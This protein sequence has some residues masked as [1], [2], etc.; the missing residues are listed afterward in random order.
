M[1]KVIGAPLYEEW[2]PIIDLLVVGS[3]GG[4][5]YNHPAIPGGGG[6]GGEVVL[7]K[8]WRP[9]SESTCVYIPPG[10]TGIGGQGGVFGDQ[11]Q[12]ASPSTYGWP[13][14]N[15]SVPLQTQIWDVKARPGVSGFGSRQLQ[16]LANGIYI[17]EFSQ[18]G[19]SGYYGGN[20]G[21]GGGH[22]NPSPSPSTGLGATPGLGGGGKGGDYS[23][24]SNNGNSGTANTGGGGGG[25]NASG[26]NTGAGGTGFVA[27]RYPTTYPP[28]TQATG[29][30]GQGSCEY[31][32]RNGYRYY[33]FFKYDTTIEQVGVAT[34]TF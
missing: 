32:I 9:P 24:V 17:A 7:L 23:P 2:P 8:N 1:G 31:T 11:R 16:H 33:A 4:G 30:N 12:L 25:G 14:P 13:G 34:F 5:G 3:G 6:Q 20:G 18:Y 29:V 21:W 27:L 26:N 22:G 19:T 28:A 10:G 15:S